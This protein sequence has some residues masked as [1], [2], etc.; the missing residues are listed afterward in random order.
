[1]NILRVVDVVDSTVQ[2]SCLWKGWDKRSVSK[3]LGEGRW[4]EGRC[5]VLILNVSE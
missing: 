2:I 3:F 5:P 1:M 4:F